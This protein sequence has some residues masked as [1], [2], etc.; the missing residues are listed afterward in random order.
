VAYSAEINYSSPTLLLFLIDQSGAMAEVV[1][2]EGR[3][4]KA[5]IVT[6]LINLRL[7]Y[8]MT[9]NSLSVDIAVLGYG[10]TVGPVLA[11][12]LADREII[13]LSQIADGPTNS[14]LICGPG[15]STNELL[16]TIPIWVAA[17]ANGTARMCQG[18]RHAFLILEQWISKHPNAFPPT[19]LH[20]TNGVSTDGDPSHAARQIQQLST[21]DGNALL[22]TCQ[23]SSSSSSQIEFPSPGAFPDD[24]SRKLFSISSSLPDPFL[25]PTKR[26]GIKIEEGAKGFVLASNRGSVF[27]FLEIGTRCLTRVVAE[28]V[29]GQSPSELQAATSL[30]GSMLGGVVGA[31]HPYVQDAIG[32]HQQPQPFA[33]NIQLPD[34]T[35]VDNVHFSLTA[36]ASLRPGS[37][38]E[39]HFWAHIETQREAVLRRAREA[40]GFSKASK[41][42]MKS[43][44]PLS[45]A[46][47]SFVAIWLSIDGVFLRDACKV[48]LW[49]GEVG[50]AVFV[51]EI[52]LDAITGPHSGSASI[53]VGGVE[54]ARMDFLL[55]VARTVGGASWVRVRVRKHRKAFASYASEDRERVLARIQG[56]QKV[57]PGLEVFV[58]VIKIRSGQDWEQTL[59]AEIPRN[60]V[61]YLFWSRHAMKSTWVDKE[62]RCAYKTKG[63][64]FIDPVPLEPAAIAPPPREL[65][66]KHFNDPLLIYFNKRNQ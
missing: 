65:S 8:L 55:N 63:E 23:I 25:E 1:E 44:G 66:R 15:K 45:L 21:S 14:K 17:R 50:V 57:M 34:G 10:S 31:A 28:N 56:M 43:Q 61:F 3:A 42:V 20:L 48:I 51:V 27:K 4:R 60:D 58:D 35:S 53:R 22:F 59:W 24:V 13:R 36:P 30:Q 40:L 54:I 49:S 5:D 2:G 12:P 64:D 46:Q 26:L 7:C 41:I 33:K 18:L 6:D 16:A 52:P 29:A 9:Y 38:A 62:W 37:K 47:G 11:E 32:R 39:I 19:V